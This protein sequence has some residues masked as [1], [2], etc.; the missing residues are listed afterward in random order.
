MPSEFESCPMLFT[1]PAQRD[2]FV[3][4][5]STTAIP[6]RHP[7]V[8]DALIQASLDPQVRSL[9]FVPAATV[10]ATQVALNAI[11]VVRDDG[12]F[13][14]DVVE[15]RQVRDVEMEGL[16]LIAL[17]DLKLVPLTLTADD[18]TRQPR[19][20]NA[21]TVWAYRFHT[22]GI[23]MRMRVL[24]VLTEDGPLQL[25]CLLKRTRG[26]RDP[27]PAVMALAC[28]DLLELDIISRPLGP[29]TMVRSRS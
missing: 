11:V 2:L 27:A 6:A 5:K 20:A 17:D 13:H 4:A 25:G 3:S 8:R 19:F 29:A 15:A 14:L 7:L 1:N 21:K 18:I 26:P 10:G 12:R 24:S 28:S 16:F 22:V 23:E 9:E